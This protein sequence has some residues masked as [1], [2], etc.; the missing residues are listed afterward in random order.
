MKRCRFC[1]KAAGHDVFHDESEFGRRERHPDGLE[2]SCRKTYN[3]Y[4]LESNRRSRAR[5]KL[6]LEPTVVSMPAGLWCIADD[7]R[8]LF[9]ARWV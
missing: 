5:K 6:G 2:H 7:F 1:S 3:A 4:V 8:L 9:C